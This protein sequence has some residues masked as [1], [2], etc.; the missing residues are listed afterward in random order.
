MIQRYVHSPLSLGSHSSNFF[1]EFK[2]GSAYH[3]EFIPRLIAL[4]LYSNLV[5]QHHIEEAVPCPLEAIALTVCVV[6][7]IHDISVTY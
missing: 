1:L 7:N 2:Y 4:K 5:A 6:C 3:H